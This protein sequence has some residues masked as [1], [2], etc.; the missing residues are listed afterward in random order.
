MAAHDRHEPRRQK[1]A[2]EELHRRD[3]QQRTHRPLLLLLHRVGERARA[4]RVARAHAGGRLHHQLP[5]AR[6]LRRWRPP[7]S[8]GCA[9][10]RRRCRAARAPR[11]VAPPP[12]GGR[13]SRRREAAARR[14]DHTRAARP[15]PRAAAAP[16][17]R[18]RASPPRA[19]AARAPQG[20]PA[21]HSQPQSAAASLPRGGRALYG[22]R[23]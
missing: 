13:T 19:A 6:A 12:R 9:P 16:P 3:K 21:R 2:W 17:P 7:K 14:R 10:A 15:G 1:V 22:V 5:G 8:A 4:V 18:A 23:R 11:E 20:R